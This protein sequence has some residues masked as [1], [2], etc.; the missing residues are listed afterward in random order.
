VDV[1]EHDGVRVVTLVQRTMRRL[2][3]RDVGEDLRGRRGRPGLRRG[4]RRG[5][6]RRDRREPRE[7]TYF[8]FW[9]TSL[10]NALLTGCIFCRAIDSSVIFVSWPH[11]TVFASEAVPV[12]GSSAGTRHPERPRAGCPP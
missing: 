4:L 2:R 10:M 3:L 6:R 1:V 7:S 9:L 5:D 12:G 11:L 8:T